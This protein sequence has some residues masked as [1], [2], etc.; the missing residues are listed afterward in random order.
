MRRCIIVFLMVLL[1]FQYVWAAA[2]QYCGHEVPVS[3]GH[4]GHHEHKH[5]ASDADSQDGSQLADADCMSCHFAHC[6]SVPVA[7]AIEG[8]ALVEQ[9]AGY[10]Q[11]YA[12]S[13]VPSG[14]ERPQR[15][16]SPL[17]VR[18]GSGCHGSSLT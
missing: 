2:A 4:F 15:S 14:L 9:N 5:V 3:S 10:D 17:A 7:F 13:R 8:T 1:P 6:T 11:P 16:S 12:L 18:F